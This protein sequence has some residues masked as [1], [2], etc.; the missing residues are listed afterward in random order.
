MTGCG[1][2]L[3]VIGLVALIAVFI[4]GSTD[5]GEPVASMTALVIAWVAVRSMTS[6]ARMPARS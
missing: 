3:V 6:R 5:P 1:C 2:I 4:F